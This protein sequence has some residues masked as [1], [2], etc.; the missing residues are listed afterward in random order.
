MT[1]KLTTNSYQIKH[2]CLFRHHGLDVSN[3][4]EKIKKKCFFVFL[5]LWKI[6]MISHFVAKFVS[7]HQSYY[8][9]FSKLSCMFT[10]LEDSQ[11]FEKFW[12]FTFY[13]G[14]GL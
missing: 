7:S 10:W 8:H 3:L 13:A 4:S 12:K 11:Y 5:G 14:F 6:A 1:P 9:F 2:V